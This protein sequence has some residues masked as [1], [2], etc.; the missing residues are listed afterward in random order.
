VWRSGVALS[1]SRGE[2]CRRKMKNASDS[3]IVILLVDT[4]VGEAR[5]TEYALR[6]GGI[7]GDLYHVRDGVEAIRFL[8]REAEYAGAP[9]PE[10]VLLDLDLARKDGCE[11]LAEVKGDPELRL[12]P[13]VILSTSEAERDVARPMVCTPTP[14]SSSRWTS[15]GLSRS[16]GP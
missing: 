13:V 10:L 8:R 6:K 14:T 5:L 2:A 4:D 11:V 12:V 15:T 7:S 9:L 16:R 3:P 1:G